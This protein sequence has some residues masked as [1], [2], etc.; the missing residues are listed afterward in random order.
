MMCR[1]CS[2][3]NSTEFYELYVYHI[4][5]K[6]DLFKLKQTI[7]YID[8]NTDIM[9]SIFLWKNLNKFLQV[10]K[11]D[12]RTNFTVLDESKTLDCWI[13]EIW[14]KPLDL[15][16]S[17]FEAYWYSINN[18]ESYL[19]IKTHHILIDGW[20]QSN[21]ANKLI[22]IYNTLLRGESPQYFFGE[23]EKYIEEFIKKT[24]KNKPFWRNKLLEFPIRSNYLVVQSAPK[25]FTI[26][27]ENLFQKISSYSQ[28]KA[29]SFSSYIYTAWAIFLS[30]QEKK[31]HVA[32]YITLSGRENMSTNFLDMIGMFINVIP[33][34]V[35][36]E[37]KTMVSQIMKEIHTNCLES[38]FHQEIDLMETLME[39][40]N[41]YELAIDSTIDL[42]TYPIFIKEEN[43]AFSME[44][45]D[46]LF[47]CHDDL[48]LAVRNRND[49]LVLELVY[50]LNKFGDAFGEYACKLMGKILKQ[51]LYS[52]ITYDAI[53]NKWGKSHES[54]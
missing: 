39:I 53:I 49:N 11:S 30:I 8:R 4:N 36:L 15:S 52:D 28:K 6:V 13:T 47:E 18:N 22:N 41:A 9:R 24:Q 31:R 29:V 21:W 50:N 3:E 17:P 33:F 25:I 44:I 46:H 20:S 48:L 43:N 2:N 54:F 38:M 26:E 34:A 37:P 1:Y 5:G 35:I 42:Q 40:P 51:M 23:Y 27:F 7:Y 32:F 10:I 16:K 19:M 14:R 45:C 12:K